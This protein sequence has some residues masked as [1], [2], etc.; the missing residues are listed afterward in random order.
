MA[1][2]QQYDGHQDCAHVLLPQR[3][4]RRRHHSG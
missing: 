3:L 4:K 1:R 2:R